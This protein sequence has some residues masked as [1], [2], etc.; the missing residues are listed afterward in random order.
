MY[1]FLGWGSLSQG[2]DGPGQKRHRYMQVS[3][4]LTA[5]STLLAAGT[6]SIRYQIVDEPQARL[7]SLPATHLN[8]QGTA[9]Q[10]IL[11]L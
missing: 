1:G 10:L 2:T 3:F 6:A 8:E 5:H 4:H 9:R 11:P 7:R